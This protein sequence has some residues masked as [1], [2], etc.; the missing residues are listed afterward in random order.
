[1]L[2]QQDW[3]S[4]RQVL[5]KIKVLASKARSA[6]QKRSAQLNSDEVFFQ[7]EQQIWSNLQGNDELRARLLRM[8]GGYWEVAERLLELARQ[9]NPGMPESWYLEKVIEE[10]ERDR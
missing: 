10:L 2:D 3:A 5:E 8:V 1:Y 4:Y 7:Q 9:K 6:A